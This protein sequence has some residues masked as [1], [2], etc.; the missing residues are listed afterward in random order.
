MAFWVGVKNF[1]LCKSVQHNLSQFSYNFKQ[2]APFKNLVKTH[3]NS[4]Q[5]SLMDLVDK[6]ERTH[7][8]KYVQA[9]Y[10]HACVSH[11]FQYHHR[12]LEE[13]KFIFFPTD[14][15]LLHLP[16]WICQFKEKEI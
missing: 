3:I 4:I 6:A 16:I 14:M 1:F 5:I 13:N 8:T 15:F 11:L 12:P 10:Y 7:N 9:I 2:L